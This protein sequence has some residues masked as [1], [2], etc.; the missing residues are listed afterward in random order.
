[1]FYSDNPISDYMA[2]QEEQEGWLDSRPV[3][4]NHNEH[5]QGKYCYIDE[6][7]GVVLCFDCFERLSE[8]EKENYVKRE[9]E[10]E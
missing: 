4:D 8:E 5:I 7:N 1:M 6:Y 2:W 9:V 10:G 3:C